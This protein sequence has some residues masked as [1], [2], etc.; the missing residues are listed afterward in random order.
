MRADKVTRYESNPA[1]AC[2]EC[3][4][5]QPNFWFR[6]VDCMHTGEEYV[7]SRKGR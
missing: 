1:G 3:S 5:T 2:G 7:D 4:G 6:N